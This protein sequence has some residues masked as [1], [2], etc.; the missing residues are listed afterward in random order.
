MAKIS[1]DLSNVKETSGFNP[2]RVDAGDYAATIVSANV[3]ESKAGKPMVTFGFQLNDHRTAVYPYYCVIQDNQ[4]WKLR[5]L[6]LSAGMKAPKKAFSFDPERLVG[7]QIGVALEDDEYDGKEKSVVDSVFSA[8]ELET[9]SKPA[10]ADDDDDEDTAP[11][12]AV[13][14]DDDELDLDDLD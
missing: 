13:E 12:A 7:K 2:R 5:N 3:G 8:S 9:E 11:A 1:V 14:E 6:L 10:P 4:L